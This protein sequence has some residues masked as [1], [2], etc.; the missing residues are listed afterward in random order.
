MG[1]AARHPAAAR[2]AAPRGHNAQRQRRRQAASAPAAVAFPAGVPQGLVPCTRVPRPIE[3]DK[4][5]TRCSSYV[6]YGKSRIQDSFSEISQSILLKT[7]KSIYSGDFMNNSDDL[8]EKAGRSN[9]VKCMKRN[10]QNENVFSQQKMLFQSKKCIFLKN[11][12]VEYCV[13]F[14]IFAWKLHFRNERRRERRALQN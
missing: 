6:F 3:L 5:W 8:S 4:L 13:V 14:S 12:P 1:S 9:S 7:V 2:A 11:F 10:L